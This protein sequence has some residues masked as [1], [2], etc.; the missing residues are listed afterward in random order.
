LIGHIKPLLHE[1]CNISHKIQ[2]NSKSIPIVFAVARVKLFI[3]QS[4][5]HASTFIK[6]LNA[7]KVV[8]S[9]S[10]KRYRLE[11]FGLS[12]KLTLNCF[13]NDLLTLLKEQG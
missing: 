8:F 6:Q 4:K 1:S 5:R 12:R 2:N 7:D 9:I 3:P 10:V 11:Q 13:D